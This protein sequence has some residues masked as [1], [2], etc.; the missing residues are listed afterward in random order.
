MPTNERRAKWADKALTSFQRETLCDREDALPDLLCDLMHLA[1]QE[2]WDFDK[3]LH[4]ARSNHE[5]EVAEPEPVFLRRPALRRA[6]RA[7]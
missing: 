4:R 6:V 5:A 1:N 2:G 3:A 7:P